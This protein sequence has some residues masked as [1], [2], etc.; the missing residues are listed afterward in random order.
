MDLA[1]AAPN[2]CARA[3][4]FPPWGIWPRAGDIRRGCRRRWGDVGLRSFG[5][6]QRL[7]GCIAVRAAAVWRSRHQSRRMTPLRFSIFLPVKP[8]LAPA[9]ARSGP[10]SRSFGLRSR[11]GD[12]RALVSL[13]P[14]DFKSDRQAGS[15]VARSSTAAW[16]N[17]HII[18]EP[19]M[20]CSQLLPRRR[21]ERQ[22][23]R[24]RGGGGA[25][26]SVPGVVGG[27]S[28]ERT[29]ARARQMEDGGQE[30]GGGGSKRN[31]LGI[32]P[33]GPN[34]GTT[35]FSPPPTS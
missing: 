18:V 6:T 13:V 17:W 23:R 19:W 10:E 7:G 30:T 34:G 16:G 12:S 25:A 22:G 29:R 11:L 2:L 9:G 27:G 24:G 8:A 26:A 15:V 31:L 21:L 3:R 1:W 28:G 33:A 14:F 32:W 20:W 4:R 35:C 5:C